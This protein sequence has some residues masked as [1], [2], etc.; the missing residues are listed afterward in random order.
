MKNEEIIKSIIQNVLQ[1]EINEITNNAHLYSD[2]GAD[3]LDLGTIAQKIDEALSVDLNFDLY[4]LTVEELISLANSAPSKVSKPKTLRYLFAHKVIPKLVFTQGINLLPDLRFKNGYDY[5]PN[6]KL[7]AGLDPYGKPIEDGLK[8]L[9]DLWEISSKEFNC[10]YIRP[11]GLDYEI[12]EESGVLMIFF[13]FPEA[14]I[15][16]DAFLGLFAW[17][18]STSSGRNYN[19]IVDN[20]ASYFT[21]ELGQYNENVLGEWLINGKYVK[22]KSYSTAVKTNQ[23][24]EDVINILQKKDK[25]LIDEEYAA[26]SGK[27]T[28][29]SFELS[30][31]TEPIFKGHIYHKIISSLANKLNIP[32]SEITKHTPIKDIKKQDYVKIIGCVFKMYG[33]EMSDN[34]LYIEDNLDSMLNKKEEDWFDCEFVVIKICQI[35]ESIITGGMDKINDLYDRYQRKVVLIEKS[36]Y[37]KVLHPLSKKI[38][39]ILPWS[40]VDS[41][42]YERDDLMFKEILAVPQELLEHNFPIDPRELIICFVSVA[43]AHKNFTRLEE[44]ARKYFE[45]AIDLN[46]KWGP[47]IEPTVLTALKNSVRD[48]KT[49]DTAKH[50]ESKSG[51]F[52]AT[53]VYGTPYAPEVIVLKEFRDNWLLGFPLGRAFVSCYY[54]IS[55]PVAHQIAKNKYLKKITKSVLIIP[56]LKIA[57]Y[58]KRMGNKV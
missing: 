24:I 34:I 33:I 36:D 48:T 14:K 30:D 8:Y 18:E 9:Q 44:K 19:E 15:P 53:A 51:C 6:S 26:I 32:E 35:F 11:D 50:D 31:D 58:L 12:F 17:D 42:L 1:V 16:G 41:E 29:D 2:L 52:I 43:I 38:H 28:S 40:S 3:E 27:L 23:I 56:L 22:H 47:Y 46:L 7:V 5:T 37:F 10:K 54:Q 25:N 49:Q 4:D 45:A 39:I 21:F 57:N 20:C 13:Y 55:P